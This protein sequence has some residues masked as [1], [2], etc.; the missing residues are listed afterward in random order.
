MELLRHVPYEAALQQ[1]RIFS[2]T[3][4]GIRSD[5]IPI[6]NI[7]HGLLEFFIESIYN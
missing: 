7:P 4:Q 1:L 2:L 6:F 5:L 3:H